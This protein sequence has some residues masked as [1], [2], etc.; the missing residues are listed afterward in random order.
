MGRRTFWEWYGVDVFFTTKSR[1][2]LFDVVCRK[3]PEKLTRI[4]AVRVRYE[5][6]AANLVDFLNDS[7]VSYRG[8]VMLRR[9][10]AR[11]RDD[12]P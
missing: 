11:L 6:D 2:R 10:F 12:D 5:A 8:L 7:K 3:P 9:V 4:R 1:R